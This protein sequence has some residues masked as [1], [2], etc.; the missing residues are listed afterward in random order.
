MSVNYNDD[1]WHGWNG[2]ECPVHG[3]SRVNWV[4]SDGHRGESFAT[5]LDWMLGTNLVAFRVIKE[6]KEPREVWG[7]G[8]S[9]WENKEEADKYCSGNVGLFR[10]VLE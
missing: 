8:S 5:N 2:G 6:H 3:R 9:F 10:E 4:S 1:L 7:D